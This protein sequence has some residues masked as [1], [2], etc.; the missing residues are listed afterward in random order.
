LK[1]E[2][3]STETQGNTA[4]LIGVINKRQNEALSYEYLDELAFLA[5]TYGVET[6]KVFTQ[7]LERPDKATF[8]GKGKLS[9]VKTYI[10]ENKIT[11]VIFDD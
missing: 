4:V 7:K 5:M 3:H 6:K 8:L 1:S 11:V 10:K 2:L 9:D